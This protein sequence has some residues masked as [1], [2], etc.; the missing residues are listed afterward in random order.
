MR[1]RPLHLLRSQKR[2]CFDPS[3][4]TVSHLC[5]LALRS[6][7]HFP[8]SLMRVRTNM[9]YLKDQW[10]G[11]AD[12]Q[13]QNWMSDNPTR[14]QVCLFVLTKLFITDTALVHYGI[15]L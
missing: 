5:I 7:P 2:H 3:Q 1:F 14:H 9:F 6:S 11:G 13:G 15:S 10:C 4:L 8:P 12:S